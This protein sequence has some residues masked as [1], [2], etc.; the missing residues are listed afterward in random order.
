MQR[1]W[2]LV[3]VVAVFAL[4]LGGCTGIPDSSAPSTVESLGV[5]AGNGEVS[6]APQ[7]GAVP[8][9]I[10]SDFLAANAVESSKHTAARAYLTPSAR[11]QWSDST[12]TVI[13]DQ[14]LQTYD[15][16][17]HTLVVT[18]RVVGTIDAN[19]IYTP[20]LLGTGQGGPPVLYPFGFSKI[21]GQYR[22]N[23]L[24][25]GL[26]ITVDQF[27]QIYRQY[28]LYYDDLAGKYLVPDLRWSSIPFTDNV[29]AATWL[30]DRL[31]GSPRP[32][33]QNAVS[34]A[35]FPAQADANHIQVRGDGAAVTVEI[36][37]SSQL[38]PAARNRLAVQLAQSLSAAGLY[39]PFTITDG[40]TS[41][42]IP[43]T[44]STSFT[45]S[46]F[47]VPLGPAAPEGA[48]Y[49]LRDGRVVDE[50]GH[51]IGGLLGKGTKV[52]TSIGVARRAGASGPL[53]VAATEDSGSS[54]RLVIG[55]QKDG[56]AATSLRGA[57]TRPVWAPGLSEVWVGVGSTLHRVTV[58][59]KTT[60]DSV[61]QLPPSAAG[62][63]I[64]SLNFS[65]DG[66]RIAI[67]LAASSSAA[68]AQLYIGAVNRDVGTVGVSALEQVSPAGVV[69]TGA[70]WSSPLKLA[71][72]GYYASSSN[73]DIFETD[74]DGSF[75]SS[76][77][78]IGLP[79]H[80]AN[81]TAS[82]YGASWVEANGQVWVQTG[83]VWISASTT[84][85]APGKNPTYVS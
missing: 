59:G 58:S 84:G 39:G 7:P 68:G 56:V 11:N 2:S 37:G 26:L 19:G 15:A 20:S 77:G 53:S 81:I 54:Q 22:I 34:T 52:L 55:T 17:K 70:D 80:P 25:N 73:A 78:I 6:T 85:Q 79:G 61:V 24:R 14:Q 4:M 63:P 75:W 12:V 10:L 16:V 32:E 44:A 64:V 41:V 46:S 51:L 72:I 1:R 69:V 42:M 27:S 43:A 35:T 74:V 40:G 29:A 65:P 83:S 71:V 62:R 30:I 8:R 38:V 18:G 5:N 9:V 67:V 50:A 47:D 57:L 21:G 48:V 36:P 49:Y 82:N 31:A 76:R 60:H 13:A 66:S 3:S 28:V 23:Q 45:A 33:L